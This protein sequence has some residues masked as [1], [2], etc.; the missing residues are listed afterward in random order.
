MIERYYH[1]RGTITGLYAVGPTVRFVTRHPEN[2]PTPLGR[3]DLDQP[4]QTQLQLTPLPASATTAVHD[5]ANAGLY[6]AGTDKRLHWL[7]DGAS[8]VVTF[9]P[10]LAAPAS[11]LALVSKDRL[12]VAVGTDVLIVNTTKGTLLQTLE[13]GETVTVL[14]SNPSG[15][16]LAVGTTTGTIT[17]FTGEKTP[18]LV[19]SASEAIHQGAVTAILFEPHELRFFSAGA[20]NKLFTTH[21]R[22][23]LDPEDRGRDSNHTQPITG[24]CHG[25]ADRILTISGDGTAKTWA[26]AGFTKP[27]TLKDD[28]AKS[29][30]LTVAQVGSMSYLV[31]AGADG[32]LRVFALTEDG[33]FGELT[34]RFYDFYELLKQGFNHA[35]PARREETLTQAVVAA[36]ERALEMIAKRVFD[37]GDH[38]LRL[39]CAEAVANSTHPKAGTATEK[40]LASQDDK[41]R[42]VGF[43]G[44]R[45][46]L[47][48][49]DLKP[50]ELALKTNH[51]DIGKLA[52]VG[53]QGLADKDDRALNA[54]VKVLDVTTAEV[55]LAALDSLERVYAKVPAE[56]SLTALASRYSDVRR[57]AL[58]RLYQR[59]LLTA[60]RVQAALRWRGE[61][62]DA[63]VRRVAF[64]MSICTRPNLVAHLRAKDTDLDRQLTELETGNL[65]AMKVEALAAVP[66]PTVKPTAE[67]LPDEVWRN[68]LTDALDA[69]KPEVQAA[70]FENVEMDD[71]V[72]E[73]RDS[74]E[75]DPSN[76]PAIIAHD[77][78]KEYVEIFG[79]DD[80]DDDSEDDDDE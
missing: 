69:Y 37:D 53:L 62:S 66:E 51:A 80:S 23:V 7:A 9:G 41:V 1:H 36:D 45:R 73:A 10:E 28:M 2:Q 12:A 54:L 32:T 4:D 71:L 46:Q 56:A 34:Q 6:W 3:L 38:G 61:D 70:L 44:L 60:D 59:K 40:L 63:E 20:D 77:V 43:Q 64:L 42:V 47:G 48:V 24:I 13:I 31:A 14:A 55:R 58:L 75:S 11:A 15:Q 74:Y 21:A 30:A 35:D 68:L 8:K 22:G 16:W 65:P 49:A 19:K 39:K 72:R 27:A 5:A 26:R 33:R 18:D 50:M 67:E 29:V 79:D 76:T 57:L 52:V 78:A 25:P 17:V